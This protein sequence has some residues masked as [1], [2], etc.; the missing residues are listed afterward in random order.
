[1]QNVYQP[2]WFGSS[3]AL[4]TG[5][6]VS[7]NHTPTGSWHTNVAFTDLSWTP[8]VTGNPIQGI[9]VAA[10]VVTTGNGLA[11]SGSNGQIRFGG[12]GFNIFVLTDVDA[13]QAAGAVGTFSASTNTVVPLEVNR[14][15][16]S[17][18]N[19]NNTWYIGTNNL[20]ASPLPIQLLSFSATCQDNYPYIQWATATETNNN[21]FTID[22]TEDGSHYETVGT[23][24]GAGNSL[25]ERSYSTLDYNNP[26]EVTYYRLSQT[27]L[28]GTVTHVKSV[29]FD[30]CENAETINGYS[31]NNVI[32]VAITSPIAATYEVMV[33][34]TLGQT[35][36]SETESAET[37][38][39]TYKLFPQASAGVYILQVIGNNKV[40]TKKVLLM[41]TK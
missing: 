25:T 14:T 33:K 6:T 29:A 38:L 30:P 10:W 24:K 23:I 3:L 27:D 2:L 36:L 5:G 13:C 18:A 7:V 11:L 26:S 21:Y 22:K 32:N 12:N 15:G 19:V 39:N 34:N 37:G 31:S 8:P 40:Y 35:V 4:T 16:L 9:S 28:D 20:V 1:M 17:L 41:S